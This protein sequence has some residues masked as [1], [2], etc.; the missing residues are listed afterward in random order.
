M[1]VAPMSED[2]LQ[3]VI[4]GWN[5]ALP[6]DQLTEQEFRRIILQDP[7]QEP[8]GLLLAKAD[9]GSPLGLTVCVVRRTVEGRDGGGRE[10]EYRRGFLK[11]FFVAEAREAEAA[12]SQLLAAAET[13]CG[14]AGKEELR[15]TEYTGPYVWPGIDLRYER[16]RGILAQHGYRD[17]WTIEDVG[18]DLRDSRL[19]ARL[20]RARAG[21]GPGHTLLTWQ[22]ESM[23]A[24]RRFAAEG[25]QPQWFPV[26]WES[27]LSQP[28]ENVLILKKRREI[29]GWAQYSP[30]RPRAGFGPILVLERARGRG[31]GSLLLLE[32]MIR[33]REQGAEYMEAG[34]ANTGFYTANGWDIVRRYAVLTKALGGGERP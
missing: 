16:L 19:Q 6:H 33:A 22:P 13:Y 14:E 34:W 28:R 15:V 32:C 23:P 1:H 24:M 26:G 31:Y 30:G 18:V 21:L 11:G 4:R 9:D 25:N 8:Q 2:D 29:L 27:G 17:I 12:A 20:D 5:A 7:N 10:D 3:D